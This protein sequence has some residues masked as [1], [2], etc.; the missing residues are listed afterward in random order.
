[1]IMRKVIKKDTSMTIVLENDFLGYLAGHAGKAGS[2]LP[3]LTELSK[4]LG[5]SVSKL[6]EQM[7]VARALG[8]VEIRPRTGIQTRP[9]SLFPGLRMSVRYALTAG[10]ASFQE[11]KD[12]REHLETSFWTQAVQSLSGEDKQKLMDLVHKA[13]TML[14]GNPIQIPHS[15][16]RELHLT[17]FSRLG[18][19][20][21]Q[22]ILEAYW[23]AYEIVGLSM[24]T[25]YTYLEDVWSHH[26]QM[27]DAIFKGDYAHGFEALT[28][29]FAI[30]ATRPSGSRGVSDAVIESHKIVQESV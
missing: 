30:L 8:L 2:Q 25:D 23:D 6:R 11:I 26:E 7:E 12:L 9:Y 1:M 15:E 5:I 29:H 14:R 28:D 19:K 10:V 24:Y 4:I 27:V 20:F 13:W 16:H 18:N 3:P 22:G 17:I 21:V